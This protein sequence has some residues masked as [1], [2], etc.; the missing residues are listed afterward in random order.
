MT[1]DIAEA[2]ADLIDAIEGF[3]AAKPGAWGD[4]CDRAEPVCLALG[5]PE[6]APWPEIATA[7]RALARPDVGLP[8]GWSI[9]QPV[10]YPDG[11]QHTATAPDGGC[12]SFVVEPG[13]VR[14][15]GVAAP[16]A[17]LFALLRA[18]GVAS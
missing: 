15:F 13:G 3:R 5:L 6:L 9:G 10:T 7:L 2:L 4:L 14:W 18:A 16:P 17:V 8:E 1:P 11:T 12:V